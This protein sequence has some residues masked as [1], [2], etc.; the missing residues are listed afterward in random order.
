MNWRTSWS[1]QS[2]Y[3]PTWYLH[4]I[5][6][7]Y[8]HH[9]TVKVHIKDQPSIII[10][11]YLT[12]AIVG[13]IWC[14]LGTWFIQ[15]LDEL[16]LNVLLIPSTF[17]ELNSATNEPTFDWHMSLDSYLILTHETMNNKIPCFQSHNIILSPQ[18]TY[19]PPIEH[20]TDVWLIPPSVKKLLIRV[21]KLCH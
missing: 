20:S 16:P 9:Q 21:N 3:S 2:I 15:I 18:P 5:P 11:G 8:K 13:I 7:S 10:H 4:L 12:A 19:S 1:T 6:H 14:H 17:Q